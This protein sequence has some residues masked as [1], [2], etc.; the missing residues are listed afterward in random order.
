MEMHRE[1]PRGDIA[2]PPAQPG[3]AAAAA[4]H[5]LSALENLLAAGDA[6]IANALSADSQSF[7]DSNRQ[8]GGQ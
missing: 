2:H 6:I 5:H 4:P 1:R 8:Q 7:L 3:S